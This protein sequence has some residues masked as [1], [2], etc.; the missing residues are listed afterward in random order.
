MTVNLSNAISTL[1]TDSLPGLFG[2]KTPPV[3]LTVQNELLEI[4]PLSADAAAGEPR[5]D[6]RTDN[7]AIREDRRTYRL[8]QSPY[9][10]AKRVRLRTRDGAYT[11]LRADEVVWDAE[12]PRRFALALRPN[13]DPSIFTHIQVMYGVVAI[14]THV[15]AD[16]VTRVRLESEDAKKLNH[17][18][19]LVI[20][21][22]QL[23]RQAL[24]DAAKSTS[25][26][27]NYGAEVEIK[28]LNLIDV[29]QRTE[30]NRTIAE[31]TLRSE[32]AIKATRAIEETEGTP[33]TRIVTPGASATDERPINIR[34]DVDA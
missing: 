22:L 30:S 7:I 2:G 32:C 6:S 25:E 28:S 19:M 12:E 15:R 10:G 17:A 1:I 33:I 3:T 34:V 23:N 26:D 21:A 27:G 29:K 5:P 14:Y 13:R 4:D 20:S 9:P 8:T 16:Q 31:I 18:V 24:I 11:T